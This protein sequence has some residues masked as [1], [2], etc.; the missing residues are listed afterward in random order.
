MR[1]T[2]VLLLIPTKMVRGRILVFQSG[3]VEE[4][5][6]MFRGILEIGIECHPE[7]MYS[8]MS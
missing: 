4:I 3:Y 5:L 6:V 1:I 7:S 2:M 8:L